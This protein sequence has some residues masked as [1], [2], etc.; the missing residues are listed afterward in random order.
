MSNFPNSYTELIAEVP[1][2]AGKSTD[3]FYTGR[4]PGWI[5]QVESDLNHG[6]FRDP[7]DPRKKHRFRL[8]FMET[9]ATM[10]LDNE[11][12]AK[13]QR[14]L[15][16]KAMRLDGVPGARFEFVTPDDF[17]KRYASWDADKPIVWTFEGDD[18]RFGPTP[19]TATGIVEL[20]FYAEIVDKAGYSA[21]TIAA[22]PDQWALNMDNETNWITQHVPELY[23]WG[24][25]TAGAMFSGSIVE[26][27]EWP[28]A[29]LRSVLGAITGQGHAH[30]P[31]LL[32]AQVSGAIA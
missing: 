30:R 14:Y 32:T 10:T 28:Q 27:A 22:N 31:G 15:G 11:R 4:I 3:T 17:Y 7:D 20:L 9:R 1:V 13:P 5:S 24:V 18:M 21:A 19:A 25:L 8:P 26:R 16:M 23:L 29:Y 12:M 6:I 2:Y